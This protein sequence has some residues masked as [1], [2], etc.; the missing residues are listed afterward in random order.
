MKLPK[1]LERLRR[2]LDE[3][4]GRF[5]SEFERVRH[6]RVGREQVGGFVAIAVSIDEQT[7]Q[8]TFGGVEAHSLGLRD[9]V[10]ERIT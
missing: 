6:E 3:R 10:M 2:P 1:T 4:R 5:R 7:G 8:H 9:V